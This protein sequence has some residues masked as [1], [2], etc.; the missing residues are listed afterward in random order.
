MKRL[1]HYLAL[2][3]FIL[4]LGLAAK[5]DL[6]DYLPVDSWGVAEVEDVAVL[7]EDLEKGP[8]GDLWN[9]PAGQQARKLLDELDFPKKGEEGEAAKEL[10]ERLKA[11][12]DKLSGQIAFSIGGLDNMMEKEDDD[13][14]GIPEI[15]F[16]AE[17][18]GTSKELGELIEWIRETDEKVS[19]G[20]EELRIEKTKVRGHEVFWLAPED[21]ADDNPD[22]RFGVFIIDGVLGLGGGRS[23][24][25]DLIHR[26][27]KGEGDSIADSPDYRNAFDEI[28]PGDLRFFVNF[29]PMLGFLDFMRENEQFKIEENPLGVTTGGI[30]DAL[31]LEGLEC[32][33][34]QMDFDERGLEIGSGLFM[35]KREGLLRLF[36]FP[37]GSVPQAPFIPRDVTTAS[38]ARYDLALFW[39]T[40]MEVFRE[41]SPALHIMIDG[42]IKAFEK[43]AGVSLR[44]DVLGSLGDEFVS[45]SDINPE[46]ALNEKNAADIESNLDAFIGEFYAISLKDA[47]RFDRSL[48]T[49]IGAFA[50]GAELFDEREHKGVVVRSF[51]EQTAISFSSPTRGLSGSGRT[52]SGVRKP[53]WSMPACCAPSRGRTNRAKAF[54]GNRKWPLP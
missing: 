41:V 29:R 36:K 14:L 11:W 49:L 45:F 21:Q 5:G 44:K 7:M 38:V 32:M 30:I 40:I 54:G 27:V 2:H 15:I 6:A 16:L 52:P 25:E 13:E 42:Q 33:A 1:L 50:P 4:P 51:R 31:G 28:G 35:G 24:M 10:I 9:S 34:L 46:E 20:D 26:M 43:Q 22:A 3:A 23:T 8:F 17:T 37:E 53:S 12:S 47:D 18:E 39:D 19:E 48:R